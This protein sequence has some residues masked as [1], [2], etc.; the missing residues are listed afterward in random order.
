MKPLSTDQEPAGRTQCALSAVRCRL[1][2]LFALG[3]CAWLGAD[4]KPTD[5]QPPSATKQMI[6]VNGGMTE[7]Y[8]TTLTA[9]HSLKAFSLRCAT[10]KL[11]AKE[12][13]LDTCAEALQRYDA[14]LQSIEAEV[15]E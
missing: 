6:T 3:L 7:I 14:A 8:P 9:K 4:T 10:E 13:D 1:S 11:K 5:P 15:G 12:P 2:A